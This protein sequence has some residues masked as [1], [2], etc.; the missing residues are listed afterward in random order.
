M[1]SENSPLISLKELE[2]DAIYVKIDMDNNEI[3]MKNKYRDKILHEWMTVTTE[4]YIKDKMI[5]AMAKGDQ[6]AV[7]FTHYN[8]DDSILYDKYHPHL[9]SLHDTIKNLLQDDVHVY[10]VKYNNYMEICISWNKML[11][12]IPSVCYT[13]PHDC[14]FA[15]MITAIASPFAI[16]L[17]VMLCH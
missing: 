3:D 8:T 10:A 5:D 4:Q 15:T 12:Y 9:F 16:I 17:L 7:L 1:Y 6:C 11:Y 2:K 13:Q 14:F